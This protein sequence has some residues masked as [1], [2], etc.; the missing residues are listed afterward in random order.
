MLRLQLERPF[1]LGP[2]PD[3]PVEWCRWCSHLHH[4]GAGRGRLLR[5]TPSTGSSFEVQK[6]ALDEMYLFLCFIAFFY[7]TCSSTLE[8]MGVCLALYVTVGI[9]IKV[10]MCVRSI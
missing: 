4:G 6:N 1:D 3:L 8:V 10:H 2:E 7:V 9:S 5:D